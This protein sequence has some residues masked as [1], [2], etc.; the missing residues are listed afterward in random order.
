M[1]K[2]ITHNLQQGT[3]EW[4]AFRFTHNGAS[5]APVMLNASKHCSRSD[6]VKAKATSVAK[7]FS[8]FVEKRVFAK[9]HETEALAR[10]IAEEIVGEE[11]FPATM[12]YGKLSASCDGL[13]LGGTDAWEHKQWNDE[14]GAMVKRGELPEDHYLQCQQTMLVTG[15][16][17]VLFMVSDGTKNKCEHTW[18]MPNVGAF[19]DIEKGWEQFDKDVADYK[20]VEVIPA[21]QAMPLKQLPTVSISVGGELTLTSNL[22]LFATALTTFIGELNLSPNTDDEFGAAAEAVKTLDKA[23]KGL[24]AAEAAALAQTATVDEMRRTVEHCITCAKQ[25]RLTLSKAVERRKEQIKIEI[26]QRGRNAFVEHIESLNKRISGNHDYMP[27]V[28]TDFGGAIKGLKSVKSL[29]DAVDGELAR[30]KIEANRIADAI[31]LNVNALRDQAKDHSFLFNDHKTLVLKD[32]DFVRLEIKSRIDEHK[33]AKEDELARIQAEAKEKA[34]REANERVENE[35]KAAAATQPAPVAATPAADPPPVSTVATTGHAAP[36]ES[37]GS[38][39]INAGRMTLLTKIGD[40]MLG[41]SNGE[42]Q[43]VLDFAREIAASRKVA[44]A[45]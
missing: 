6:L 4:H 25:A 12:S 16:K 39:A 10:S 38:G 41:L 15:A 8:D 44:V 23:E 42:L 14:L 29:N 2:R 22:D 26:V 17:R 35:R 13:T 36:A 5:G 11:L 19:E 30:A 27:T 34:E 18:V 21:A 37:H 45:S 28:A 3:P 32:P 40:T 20:H 9:G 33:K 7:E 31:Q 24:A 43:Q 1:R